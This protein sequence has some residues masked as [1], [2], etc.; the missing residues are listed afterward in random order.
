MLGDYGEVYVLDWG[1]AKILN[2]PAVSAPLQL[3]DRSDEAVRAPNAPRLTGV[4][5]VLGTIAYA[6]PEQSLALNDLIDVRTDVFSLGAI[7][8]ELLTWQ[9]LRPSPG[10]DRDSL[11]EANTAPTYLGDPRPSVRAPLHSV[12]PELE[13]I[14]LRATQGEPSARYQSVRA[15]LDELERA[16]SGE[17]ATELRQQLAQGHAVVANAAANEALQDG[18][19]AVAARQ[20][21][22]RE[23]GRAVGIDSQ[24]ALALGTLQRLIARPPT[25]LP[26]PVEQAMRRSLLL[27]ERTRLRVLAGAAVALLLL[28]VTLPLSHTVRDGALMLALGLTAAGSAGLWLLLAARPRTSRSWHYVGHALNLGLYALVGRLFGP[29]W[30]MTVPLA[31]NTFLQSATPDIR[32]R[33]FVVGSSCA[34]VLVMVGLEQLGWLD[35]SYQ[36]RGSVLSLHSSVL[37]LT[38]GPSLVVLTLAALLAITVPAWSIGELTTRL[39]KSERHL[40]VRAWHLAQV[41]PQEAQP[42]SPSAIAS[43]EQGRPPKT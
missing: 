17:Q 16:V 11:P 14:C 2:G 32:F 19:G 3:S 37:E 42:I 30:L 5:H 33:R 10:P 31:M 40:R 25:Q 1:I 13:A 27:R 9:R 4:N 28:I 24:S 29:L 18:A 21:A 35:A 22:I 39:A 6:S 41:L 36:F 43:A 23:A 20:K 12:P 8:F 7:L 34:L 38:A 26:P 15:L